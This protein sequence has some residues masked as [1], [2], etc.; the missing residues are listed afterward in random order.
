MFTPQR[1]PVTAISPRSA[2]AASGKGKVVAFA[3]PPAPPPLSFL[4]GE[5]GVLAAESGGDMA[6]WKRFRE[7]GLLDEAAMERKDREAL[8]HK[9]SKLQNNVYFF[10]SL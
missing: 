10:L 1:Q 6:D 3:D 4:I 2:S 9:L 7:A 8:L 5:N